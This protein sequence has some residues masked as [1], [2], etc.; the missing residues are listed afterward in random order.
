M[1]PYEIFYDKEPYSL[2]LF[3]H[4]FDESGNSLLLKKKE[5]FIILND[6]SLR[7]LPLF[8]SDLYA[9]LSLEKVALIS[10]AFYLLIGKDE[11]MGEDFYFIS[12]L[13]I[14]NFIRSFMMLYGELSKVAPLQMGIKRLQRLIMGKDIISYQRID[15]AGLEKLPFRGT[16]WLSCCQEL[17]DDLVRNILL[18]HGIDLRMLINGRM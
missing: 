4:W 2:R 12:F 17:D 1:K 13:G 9:G 7:S 5:P 18:E 8:S 3:R 10:K 14:D 16:E 15:T 6:V 11:D